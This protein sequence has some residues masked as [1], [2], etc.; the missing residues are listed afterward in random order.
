MASPNIGLMGKRA[1]APLQT[2][3]LY[4]FRN[5]GCRIW[6]W[7]V[8]KCYFG[9]YKFG[10]NGPSRPPYMLGVLPCTC[11]PHSNECTM[12]CCCRDKMKTF[13]CSNNDMD[14][15]PAVPPELQGLTQ[16]EMLMC[17]IMPMMSLY[18]LP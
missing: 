2:W 11:A 4:R 7:Q 18:R 3:A 1:S 8:R 9:N 12:S 5:F 14:P 16:V 15:G 10:I 17:A 13:S 6:K